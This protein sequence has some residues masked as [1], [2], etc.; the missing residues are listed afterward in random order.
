[1]GILA[2]DA[3][4]SIFVVVGITVNTVCMSLNAQNIRKSILV[5]SPMVLIYDVFA[6]SISGAVYEAV[7][8]VSSAIG[9]YRFYNRKADDGERE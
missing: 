6:K 7:A 2:W 4:Y 3:W 9:L 1:M 8:I 5:T